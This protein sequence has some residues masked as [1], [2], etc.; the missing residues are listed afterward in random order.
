MAH[1]REQP[2]V[3]LRVDRDGNGA[4]RGGRTRAGRGSEELSVAACGV[5][6]PRRAPRRGRPA[7]PRGRVP[8][9]RATGWPPTKRSSATARART[10]FVEP[11]SVTVTKGAA[12]SAAS[13][14]VVSIVTW[15]ATTT[16]SAEA[17]ASW[18][19]PSRLERAPAHC[20]P[21]KRRRRPCPTRAR[22][23]PPRRA[24]SPTDAPMSPVPITATCI[25]GSFASTPELPPALGTERRSLEPRPRLEP[26]E[27]LARLGEQRL[28][29]A[30]VQLEQA[31]RVLE[32]VTASQ[33]GISSLRNRA[34]AA[35]KPPRRRRAS[36]GS[37]AHARRAAAAARPDAATRS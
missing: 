36:R 19:S 27:D 24:A 2:V 29:L 20:R 34:A 14:A 18:P 16:S 21:R 3:R 22:H 7:R 30:S 15:T 23:G 31:L 37:G 13:T 33:N 10:L 35:A 9:R 26:R 25:S 4:E 32:L 28:R 5:E 11:T 8:R 17:A 6:K 1:E 12:V